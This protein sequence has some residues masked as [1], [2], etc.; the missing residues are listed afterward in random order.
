M[1]DLIFDKKYLCFFY[2]ILFSN[3]LI[4]FYSNFIADRSLVHDESIIL[5]MSKNMSLSNKSILRPSYEVGDR[6]FD[7]WGNNKI[8][9]TVM[10]TILMPPVY[11]WIISKLSQLINISLITSSKI[12][13]FIFWIGTLFFIYG[14]LKDSHNVAILS[15]S[16]CALSPELCIEMMQTEHEGMLTFFGTGACYFIKKLHVNNSYIYSFISGAFLGVSFLAKLWLSGIFVISIG[17]YLIYI[18]IYHPA[19]RWFL[20]KSFILLLLGFFIFSCAHLIYIYIN[21]PTQITYWVKNI[22]LGLFQSK[23]QLLIS[24]GGNRNHPFWYYFATI[25]RH[26]YW[27]LPIIL[28]GLPSIIKK[29]ISNKEKKL[30]KDES[31]VLIFGGIAAIVPLSLIT[32]KE[33]LYILPIIFFIYSIAGY[34]ALV[35]LEEMILQSISYK[36]M[37]LNLVICLFLGL[38]IF[39]CYFFGIKSDDITEYYTFLHST[40]YILFIIFLLL[41]L[42]KNPKSYYIIYITVLFLIFSVSYSF[43]KTKNEHFL[44]MSKYIKPFIKESTAHI[45][46]VVAEDYGIIGFQVWNMARRWDMV[47]K[48]EENFLNNENYKVL[49]VSPSEIKDKEYNKYIALMNANFDKKIFTF[50]QDFSDDLI[51]TIYIRK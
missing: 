3:L 17:L 40:Y 30:I 41:C 32:A 50:P 51:Y 22:Y 6:N 2:T 27:I 28:F 14:I 13:Q 15:V 35:I 5:Q 19:K 36:Y 24:E 10:S 16:M 45:P 31:I 26:H 11:P 25:Y 34:F 49:I 48:N 23:E 29:I 18:F 21:D 37:V 4:V 43:H 44:L 1:T 8:S 38:I 9:T 33:P 12:I 42:N 20:F 46:A 39:L 47:V 7:K